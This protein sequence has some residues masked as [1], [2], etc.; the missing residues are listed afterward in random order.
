MR[1]LT[2]AVVFVAASLFGAETVHHV[3]PS[4]SAAPA[5]NDEKRPWQLVEAAAA[6]LPDTGGTLVIHP[7]IYRERFV[8]KRPARL[9]APEGGVRIGDTRRDVAATTEFTVLT[10]NTHLGGDNAGMPKW[11]DKQRAIEIGQFLGSQHA[12]IDLV[13]LCELWDE[14]FLTG[15]GV[16]ILHLAGYA[17]AVH[18][19]RVA[20]QSSP[21]WQ[22][23]MIP[24]MMNSGLAILSDQKLNDFD[25]A[26]F[27]YCSGVCLIGKSPDCLANKGYVGVTVVKDGFTIRVINTHT[28]AGNE[29][30]SVRAREKQ[31]E[32]LETYI[33]LYRKRNPSHA[34]L[35]M[36]DMNTIGESEQYD[37]AVEVFEEV[38][39][40][41][42]ARNAP[43][44]SLYSD[45]RQGDTLTSFNELAIHFDS[46]PYDQRLDYVWYFPS[47][48]GHVVIQPRH[49]E[50]LLP[51]G[52]KITTGDF[53]T[54][55][56]SDH[57]PV[58]AHV[59]L[60]RL[61]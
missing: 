4:G 37:F 33:Y 54:D 7:G 40:R 12:A 24:T 13:S 19:S 30:A 26:S 44:V 9:V 25:Q 38:G 2:A 15:E 21:C 53:T 16:D 59:G 8:L 5:A 50:R 56:L 52:G 28:Q 47:L 17:N 58:L 10:W 34:V 36:G 3:T 61:K 14:D 18:G 20:N 35:L 23:Y 29:K 22:G 42:A 27:F 48:D 57:Y 51:H 11:E 1:H 31:L 45:W 6:A 41:D 32:Q 43:D 60:Y 46:T 49:V 55:E 39:G